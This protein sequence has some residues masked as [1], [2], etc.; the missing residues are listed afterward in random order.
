MPVEEQGKGA[1]NREAKPRVQLGKHARDEKP[2]Q[3]APRKL[4]RTAS[5]KLGGQSNDLWGDIMGGG[6]DAR[7]SPDS[8]ARPSNIYPQAKPV[9]LEPESFVAADSEPNKESGILKT[10]FQRPMNAL[11]EVHHGYFS[12]QA[13]LVHGFPPKNVSF[14]NHRERVD[15]LIG[16]EIEAAKC[17]QGRRRLSC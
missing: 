10:T 5:T 13:F 12:N 3:E 16:A 7:P 14:K 17:P 6:F 2:P 8:Q 15:I 4:R 1:W 11:S 9:V